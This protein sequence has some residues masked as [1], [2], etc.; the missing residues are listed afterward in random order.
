MHGSTVTSSS[1]VSSSCQLESNNG[2]HCSAGD[3]NNLVLDAPNIVTDM[4]LQFVSEDQ[5]PTDITVVQVR[6]CNACLSG[7]Y[8]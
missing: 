7:A 1:R 6:A 5:K 2:Y 3:C 8:S 4:M